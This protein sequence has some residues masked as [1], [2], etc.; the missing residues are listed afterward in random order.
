M[1][2]Y[3]ELVTV[4]RWLE[5][6]DRLRCTEVCR[7]WNDT[8]SA[9]SALMRDITFKIT[10]R[11]VGELVDTLKH[12]ST[13]RY[14]RIMARLD[15]DN[16]NCTV[17]KLLAAIA[18]RWEVEYLRLIGGQKT[19][20]RVMR[21]ISFGFLTELRLAFPRGVREY[22]SCP[23]QTV[24]LKSLKYFHYT[25]FEGMNFSNITILRLVV[26]N[27]ERVKYVQKDDRD[28][29]NYEHHPLVELL[30]TSNLKRLEV[31]G[32]GNSW[33]KFFDIKRPFL[34][35]LTVRRICS[36]WR[37]EHWKSLFTNMPNL[38]DLVIVARHHVVY[39]RTNRP[40]AGYVVDIGG[41][42]PHLLER[43]HLKNVC[44]TG[45]DTLRCEKLTKL[46][47]TNVM[48]QPGRCIL[49]APNLTRMMLQRCCYATFKPRVGSELQSVKMECLGD[50]L[51]NIKGFSQSF[52][53]LLELR[54][55]IDEKTLDI[56]REFGAFPRLRSLKAVFQSDERENSCD[57]LVRAICSNCPAIREVTI[58]T[59][60]VF[61][62]CL[63]SSCRE[64]LLGL[65]LRLLD[66]SNLVITD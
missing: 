5:P 36:E 41:L 24:V 40:S 7:D 51:E 59:E 14:R 32:M 38:R 4:F 27:L 21:S 10:P 39:S 49:F 11:I 6:Q 17:I 37:Y 22:S 13:R 26:P 45:R 31:H 65:S 46:S 62:V 66:I 30:E 28:Y 48:V 18:P 19:I 47:C 3:D 16:V 2:P 52:K 15:E 8:I 50:D 33:K 60:S 44:F 12:H 25:Q 53:N 34:E 57:A 55:M 9:S 63:S 23:T 61:D 20:Q 35:H 58:Q 29:V 1:L 54:F 42:E 64:Q 56:I 43:L